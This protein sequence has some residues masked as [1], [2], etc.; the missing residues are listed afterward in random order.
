MGGQARRDQGRCDRDASR[1]AQRRMARL[2][3]TAY[4]RA[5]TLDSKFTIAV[6]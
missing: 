3:L 4:G 6:H 5:D 2:A 1:E